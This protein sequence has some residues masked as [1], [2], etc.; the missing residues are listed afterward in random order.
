MERVLGYNFYFACMRTEKICSI[1]N[2][3][4]VVGVYTLLSYLPTFLPSFLPSQ[5]T[6][7]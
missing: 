5:M 2:E 1:S 7:G 6:I 3:F 4:Q